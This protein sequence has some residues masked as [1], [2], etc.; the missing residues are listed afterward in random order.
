MS[1]YARRQRERAGFIGRSLTTRLVRRP[2]KPDDVVIIAGTGRSGTTWLAELVNYAHDYRYCFE[3]FDSGRAPHLPDLASR[4]IRC[5]EDDEALIGPVRNLLD[6]RV[7]HRRIDLYNP[8]SL[9]PRRNL[10]IKDIHAN[11]ALGWIQRHFPQVRIAFIIRHPAAVAYSRARLGWTPSLERFTN[12]PDLV[13]DYLTPYMK[14][15]ADSRDEFEM[16]VTMWC[17]EHL[18][19]IGQLDFATA[20]VTRYEDL[21]DRPEDELPR[22]FSHIGAQFDPRV[23]DVLARPSH[24]NWN[25]TRFYTTRTASEAAPL[26]EKRQ[27]ES[28]HRIMTA[29]GLSNLYDADGRPTPGPAAPSA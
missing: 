18:V 27:A 2:G 6:G 4:Y 19:A 23:L 25:N 17:I 3:P 28:A 10:L 15:I 8:P 14:S 5:E 20:C 16:H 26:I 9:L 21:L 13:S 24:T 29:F 7:F 22:V 11:L 1:G 12:Q